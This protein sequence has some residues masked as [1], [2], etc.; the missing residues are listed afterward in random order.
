MVL[1]RDVGAIPGNNFTLEQVARPRCLEIL[2]EGGR[3]V[4]QGNAPSPSSP[5]S[6]NRLLIFAGTARY[7]FRER[8]TDE[9]IESATTEAEEIDA[10]SAPVSEPLTTQITLRDPADPDQLSGSTT[11]V[12]LAETYLA[13]HNA[14]VSLPQFLGV[15]VQGP[16]VEQVGTPQSSAPGDPRDLCVFA[17]VDVERDSQINRLTYQVSA[18]VRSENASEMSPPRAHPITEYAMNPLFK[19]FTLDRDVHVSTE[20]EGPSTLSIPIK[21][22]RLA[23]P[24]IHDDTLDPG[25]ANRLLVF[26]G[27]VL[28]EVRGDEDGEV[29]RGVVRVRLG[30]LL[31]ASVKF[32]GAATAAS[33]AAFH[34]ETDNVLFGVDAAETLVGPKPTGSNLPENKVRDDGSITTERLPTVEL[35][36]FLYAAV[37]S[38]DRR[39][40]LHRIS[41]QAHV[42]VRDT[43]PDFISILVRQDASQNFQSEA[44]IRPETKWDLQINFD[45]PVALPV[46]SVHVE[47]DNPLIRVPNDFNGVG[48]L[49]PELRVTNGNTNAVFTAP[50]NKVRNGH[51]TATIT[52]TFKR[53]DNTVVQH[54]ATVKVFAPG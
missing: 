43:N 14:G 21:A 33:L 11:I 24:N 1:R 30:S 25:P 49:V 29:T 46:V 26:A 39:S 41:Y 48:Q 17:V 32:V 40:V 20:V 51:E 37:Q 38:Q 36:L 2:M 5:D 54:K 50:Q 3:Q 10:K 53:L 27:S 35:Y 12:A 8:L 7:G 31:G 22:G 4:F 28:A 42:L 23:F 47:S 45:G 13:G 19:D 15:G 44:F 52:G 34:S 6:S 18:L 9:T 16:R